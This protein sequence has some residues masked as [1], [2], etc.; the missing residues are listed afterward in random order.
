MEVA[1]TPGSAG[2]GYCILRVPCGHLLPVVV[3]AAEMGKAQPREKVVCN[4]LKGSWHFKMLPS[5]S[6]IA[7]V[8]FQLL[9]HLK[10]TAQ[11]EGLLR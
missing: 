1:V 5:D 10:N 9:C 4:A 11:L 3:E 2:P 7:L 6:G 8:F